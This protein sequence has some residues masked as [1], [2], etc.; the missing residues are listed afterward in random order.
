MKTLKITEAQAK[1]LYNNSSA[2][3][4]KLLEEHFGKL[5]F[6][7]NPQGVWILTEDRRALTVD[8]YEALE[9]K[10]LSIG[11]G[12]ST[13]ETAFIISPFTTQVLPFGA[14]S[15]T[16][17][18]DIA[19]DES[20]YDNDAA[21]DAVRRAHKGVEFN[22]WDDGRFPA[23]GA[24]AADSC[25]DDCFG[26]RWTL[27]TLATLKVMSKKVQ[28]INKALYAAGLPVL[29]PNYHWS[30]TVNKNNEATAFVVYLRYGYV[31]L[32]NQGSLYYVRAVS[33]FH[34]EDFEF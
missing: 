12:V 21:T 7:E 5:A 31:Y 26:L 8:A 24:P 17:Y 30:S 2:S 6:K 13:K 20:S 3:L 9:D 4:K 34:F 18:D 29:L 25:P 10:P 32:I 27:P 14:K 33:A 11:V 15:V 22:I 28:S 23:C 1:E 16:D 19:Y